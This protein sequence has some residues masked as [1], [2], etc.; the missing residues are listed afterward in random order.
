MNYGSWYLCWC[1][2]YLFWYNW[3]FE[4]MSVQQCMLLILLY[5]SLYLAYWLFCFNIP[6]TDTFKGCVKEKLVPL[7][8]HAWL[9]VKVCCEEMWYFACLSCLCCVLHRFGCI[10]TNMTGCDR[11]LITMMT[12]MDLNEFIFSL[13][14]NIWCLWL[15]K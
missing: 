13:D 5:P 15:T 10:N 11:G 3:L 4:V 14:E 6:K 12:T 2:F 1:C 7:S 9:F 8:V